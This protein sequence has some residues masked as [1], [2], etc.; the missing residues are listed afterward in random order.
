MMTAAAAPPRSPS[1]MVCKPYQRMTEKSSGGGVEGES[2]KNRKVT[3]SII[4]LNYNYY[5][6]F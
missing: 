1:Q 4:I 3:D 6:Y 5:K 2:K